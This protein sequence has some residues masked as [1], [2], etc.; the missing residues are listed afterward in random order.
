MNK[1]FW[2]VLPNLQTADHLMQLL[3]RVSVT[4]VTMPRDRSMIRIYIECRELIAKRDIYILEAA[5][6][7]QFFAHK[8]VTVKIYERYELGEMTAEEALTRYRDSILLELKGWHLM[9]YNLFRT[10][11]MSFADPQVL[12]LEAEDNI[13]NLSLIHI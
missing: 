9:D 10:A 1:S 13:V 7:K 6:K 11:K 3:D 8:N 5:I 12:V 2:E 4:R